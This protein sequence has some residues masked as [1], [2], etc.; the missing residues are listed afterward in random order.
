VDKGLKET[1]LERM[2]NIRGVTIEAS[3]AGHRMRSA[4]LMYEGPKGDRDVVLALAHLSEIARVV[5]VGGGR[6]TSVKVIK[7]PAGGGFQFMSKEQW[8]GKVIRWL[9]RWY[10]KSP[11][12]KK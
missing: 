5:P 1:W 3:C 8:W 6:R 10:G 12:E 4:Y 9:E 11:K 7:P 2:N